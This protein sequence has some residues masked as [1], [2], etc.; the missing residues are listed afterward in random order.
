MNDWND[1]WVATLTVIG[2]VV[3]A[4]VGIYYGFQYVYGLLA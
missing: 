1:D 3:L 4:V 2:Y